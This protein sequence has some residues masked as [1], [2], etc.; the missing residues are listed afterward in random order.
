MFI[1]PCCW[2]ENLTVHQSPKADELRAEID[3]YVQQGWSDQQ[4][5][6]KLIGAYSRRILALPEG[7]QGHVLSWAPWVALLSGGA[8]VSWVIARSVRLGATAKPMAC[9]LLCAGVALGQWKQADPP[10]KPGGGM[11]FLTKSPKGAVYISWIDAE[12]GAGQGHALRMAEWNGTAWVRP[13]T[14]ARGK[15]WFVNWADFPAVSVANDGSMLAHWLDRAPNGGTYGYG[16]RVARREPGAQG[17]WREVAAFHVNDPKDYA[18]FLSFVGGRSAAYLAPPAGGQQG[19]HH[20]GG[21]EDHGHLKTLRVAEF[22]AAGEVVRDVEIDGDVCSCCQTASAM[23]PSGMV[24]AYRD[25]LPGEIRDISIVRVRDGKAG[26][27]EVLHRDGWQINGC[28]TEGPTIAAVGRTAGIAWTT[29]AGGVSRLQLAW[30]QDG[31]EKFRAPVRADD[32]NPLG[33]PHLA[34]VD[35][36]Q[37]LLVWLEKVGATSVEVRLRRVGADGRLGPSFKVASVGTGRSAGLPKVAVHGDQ[38][39]VAWREDTVRAGWLPLSSV[40]S[41]VMRK[42]VRP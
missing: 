9:L 30:S 17:A 39:L 27:P 5:Q 8:F 2:R 40:P 10:A 6:D 3:G 35:A 11:P 22:G 19:G 26:T 21:D 42:E 38:V 32:G 34:T 4:I 14:I 12:G 24:I 15:R 31:G 20:H 28:P 13:E 23:T 41:L 18:G 16:V 36:D 1:A 33:R 7:T 25:H 29:R 37:Q